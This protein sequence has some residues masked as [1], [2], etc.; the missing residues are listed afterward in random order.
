MF[1]YFQDQRRHEAREAVRDFLVAGHPCAPGAW[2]RNAEL[3]RAV[4]RYLRAHWRFRRGGLDEAAPLLQQVTGPR[5]RREADDPAI[6]FC[7][8]GAAVRLLGLG[9]TLVGRQ[10]CLQESLALTAGLRGLGF[11]VQVVV[12]YPIVE[13]RSGENF[14]VELHAW[15]QLGGTAIADRLV[16]APLHL[17]EIARYPDNREVPRHPAATSH[18]IP[19]PLSGAPYMVPVACVL[20]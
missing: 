1:P 15:P 4:A 5:V 14:G 9:R 12:G 3:P 11:P 18:T 19:D 7:A 10:P 20:Q 8:R 2:V 17:V 16:G 13:P 6:V